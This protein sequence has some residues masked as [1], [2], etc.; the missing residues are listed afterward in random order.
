M[1]PRFKRAADKTA[2]PYRPGGGLSFLTDEFRL[3]CFDG[4]NAYYI[5]RRMRAKSERLARRLARD[6]AEFLRCTGLPGAKSSETKPDGSTPGAAPTDGIE[7]NLPPRGAKTGINDS[8]RRRKSKR[9]DGRVKVPQRC[10][11][12]RIPIHV[13]ASE[14]RICG[15]VELEAELIIR[16]RQYRKGQRNIRKLGFKAYGGE[17][18]YF[19]ILS[20]SAPLRSVRGVTS[21]KGLHPQYADARVEFRL[22]NGMPLPPR[23]SAAA[24]Q[25]QEVVTRSLFKRVDTRVRAI[26]R[27]FACRSYG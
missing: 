11:A 25:D 15:S 7:H 20:S 4:S 21:R 23:L 13:S 10:L 22:E 19:S 12:S 24:K 5:R 17:T 26:C 27:L 16:P 3:A 9:P 6:H 8:S 2:S 14:G 18:S 1:P